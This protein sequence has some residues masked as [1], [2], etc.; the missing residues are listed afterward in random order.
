MSGLKSVFFKSNANVVVYPHSDSP[1]SG[2][3]PKYAIYPVSGHT[4]YAPSP[5]LLT[6]VSCQRNYKD[7]TVVKS[8]SQIAPLV[9]FCVLFSGH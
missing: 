4:C 2:R 5:I 6:E 7:T 9:T 8:I 1:E 3:K